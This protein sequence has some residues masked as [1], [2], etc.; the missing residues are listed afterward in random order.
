VEAKVLE[1]AEKS[2]VS[3]HRPR[4]FIQQKHPKNEEENFGCGESSDMHPKRVFFLM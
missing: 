3:E 2:A 4:S 1:F